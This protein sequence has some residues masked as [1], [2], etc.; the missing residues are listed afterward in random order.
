MRRVFLLCVAPV[1]AM[2]QPPDSFDLNSKLR[3]HA[4]S[5]YSPWSIAGSAAYAGIL[6]GI[7]TPEEWGHGGGA[8]QGSLQIGLDFAS[9][10]G[11]EF[12]PDLKRKILRRKPTSVHTDLRQGRP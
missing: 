6:H 11:A 1:L 2:A 9:N 10:L 4:E 5:L 12:L 8:S 7:G 3:F